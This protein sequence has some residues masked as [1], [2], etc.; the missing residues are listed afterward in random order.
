MPH[1]SCRSDVGE[2]RPPAVR[3]GRPTGRSRTGLG[4]RGTTVTRVCLQPGSAV[5]AYFRRRHPTA[6]RPSLHPGP[7]QPPLTPTRPAPR[8][9]PRPVPPVGSRAGLA[10][11]PPAMLSWPRFSPRAVE[12]PI[13]SRSVIGLGRN[14]PIKG[15][16]LSRKTGSSTI[17]LPPSGPSP[18][19]RHPLLSKCTLQ[20][21]GSMAQCRLGE[22]SSR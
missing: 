11:P 8:W 5:V 1:P 15:T 17:C 18:F 13:P 3:L 19:N 14:L 21:S 12:I 7:G 16:I 10:A 4:G 9:R 2:P 20:I 22:P 6:T